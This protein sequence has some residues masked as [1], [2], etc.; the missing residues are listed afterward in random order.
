MELSKENCF[1]TYILCCKDNSLYT[2]Y[3]TN[4]LYRIKNH[5]L[6]KGAKYTRGRTP[7]KLVYYEFFDN[8]SEAL[9]K[10][11]LIKKFTKTQKINYIN[12][13]ITQEIK[14][15]IEKINEELKECYI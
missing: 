12:T 6:K 15:N 1:Y 9:K 4:L 10:E 14:N 5:N 2:G 7:V 11:H 8:K 13:N 3:T